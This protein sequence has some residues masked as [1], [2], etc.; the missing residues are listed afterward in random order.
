MTPCVIRQR[1]FSEV[2]QITGG[3]AVLALAK[4]ALAKLRRDG[5][6]CP[7]L[8]HLGFSRYRSLHLVLAPTGTAQP[9]L[10]SFLQA[11]PTT[12]ILLGDVA[13]LL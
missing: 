12:I 10:T 5:Q 3:G 6:G 2:M 4:L 9:A 13:R 1:K 7:S 11:Y 8:T